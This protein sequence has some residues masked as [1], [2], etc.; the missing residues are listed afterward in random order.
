MHRV[1]CGTETHIP[2]AVIKQGTNVILRL[3]MIAERPKHGENIKF[4]PKKMATL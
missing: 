3:S 1:T 2:G 4:I